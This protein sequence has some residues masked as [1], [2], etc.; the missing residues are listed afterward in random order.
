MSASAIRLA[1]ALLAKKPPLGRAP[2]RAGLIS[3]AAQ[4]IKYSGC[5]LSLV[6]ANPKEVHRFCGRSLRGSCGWQQ[7]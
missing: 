2:G 5:L 4:C 6:E 1:G 3:P 7:P